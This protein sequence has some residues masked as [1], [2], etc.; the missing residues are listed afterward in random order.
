MRND[1]TSMMAIMAHT[2]MPWE[3]LMTQAPTPRS[4]V[5]AYTMTTLLRTP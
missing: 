1:P 4:A 5:Q 2:A 3:L